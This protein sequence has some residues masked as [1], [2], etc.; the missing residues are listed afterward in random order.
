MPFVAGVWNSKEEL[1]ELREVDRLFEP[2]TDFKKHL[3]YQRELTQWLNVVD[4]FKKWY[5]D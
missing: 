1:S 5:V 3:D 2:D 4:R